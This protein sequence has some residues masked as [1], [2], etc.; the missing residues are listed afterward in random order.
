[1]L[2]KAFTLFIVVY[3]VMVIVALT[4]STVL[5][6]TS[7]NA[8]VLEYEPVTCTPALAP[9]NTGVKVPLSVP[10]V[11]KVPPVNVILAGIVV[12]VPVSV[13]VPIWKPSTVPT[14]TFAVPDLSMFG[15]KL[16]ALEK[17]PIEYILFPANIAAVI[18]FVPDANPDAEIRTEVPAGP[19]EGVR[20]TVGATIVN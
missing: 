20:V 5:A 16:D 8:G 7:A 11:A 6:L 10:F 18:W 1:M 19:V 15:V 3:V 4:A 17:L 12:D 13:A 9:V 14:V 2:L